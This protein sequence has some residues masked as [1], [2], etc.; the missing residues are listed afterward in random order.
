M[1][2]AGWQHF[3]HGSD[4][5][6]RGFGPTRAAAFAEAA[7]ALTAA[8]AEL[9][10][11]RPETPVEISCAA[12]DD[13]RLLVAWLNAVVYEMATRAMLFARFEVA[14]ADGRLTATA[15]G[16]PVDIARHQPAAE[17]KGAT[18]TALSVRRRAD[19]GWIAEC[20]VDV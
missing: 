6:V 11:V 19:G 12:P 5:G 14:I 9:D 10:S 4:V 13:E 7:R 17:V 16:E 18:Y 15:W 20:V 3:E 2:E 8:V 1:G